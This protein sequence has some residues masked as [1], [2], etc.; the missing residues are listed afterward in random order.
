MTVQLRIQVH[1]NTT[2]HHWVTSSLQHNAPTLGH[3]FTATQ[4]SITG[5]P[6]PNIP[7]KQFHHLQQSSGLKAL[8]PHSGNS[9]QHFASFA[10]AQC[11]NLAHVCPC[12]LFC[13]LFKLDGAFPHITQKQVNLMQYGTRIQNCS[14]PVTQRQGADNTFT[15]E[16]PLPLSNS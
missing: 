4:R 16:C 3:Q 13:L 10:P 7:N 5:S 2:L 14:V 9:P 8:D 12:S 6:V 1:C 11:S 15:S